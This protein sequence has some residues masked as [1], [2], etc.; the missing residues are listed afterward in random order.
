MTRLPVS[1]IAI[2]KPNHTPMLAPPSVMSAAPATS[3]PRMEQLPAVPAPERAGASLEKTAAAEHPVRSGP[4]AGRIIWTGR[5]QRNAWVVIEGRNVSTG[6]LTGELPARPVHINVYPAD[7]TNDGLVLYSANMKYAK[8]ATETPGQ[9]NGWNRTVYTWNPQHSRDVA[10]TE[11]PSSA[12]NW[13]RVA[14]RANSPV[15]VI[16]IDWSLAQ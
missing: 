6:S 9:Q 16:V 14:L 5:L 4:V 12:N 7:L 1:Q 8:S 3:M 11:A 13:N 2:A 10:V 15:S